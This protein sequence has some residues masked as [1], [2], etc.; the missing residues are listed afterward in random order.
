MCLYVCACF[1]TIVF[2][3]KRQKHKKIENDIEN[4][5]E[6]NFKSKSKI[7]FKSK[8]KMKKVRFSKYIEIRRPELY[9]DEMLIS[10]IHNIKYKQRVKRAKPELRSDKY[11]MNM[12]N[13][14][15]DESKTHVKNKLLKLKK[16][17]IYI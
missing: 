15:R 16:N 9:K 4:D 11:Y 2:F 6:M 17:Y 12:R 8:S 10:K 7:N 14:K 1:N 13:I 3:V 5:I